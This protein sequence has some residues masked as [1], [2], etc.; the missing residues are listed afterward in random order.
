[1]DPVESNRRA[2]DIA[3]RKYVEESE[4]VLSASR[5]GTLFDLER[6]LLAPVVP[7]SI[8]VHLQSGNGTDDADLIRLGAVAVMGVDFS[9]VA[10]SS[11]QARADQLGLTIRYVT[12][13][14]VQVPLR[15]AST[16]V[17]YTGKGA[18]MWLP[19]LRTW[20]AETARLLRPGGHLFVFEAHPAAAL[21]TR[22][23][24]QARIRPDRTYFG[25]TRANDSFPASAIARFSVNPADEAV[26]WQ[27]TLSDVVTA[28]L[29]A[30]LVL[31]HLGEYPEPFWRPSGE[32]QAAA[33]AGGLP[34]SFALLATKPG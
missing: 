29:E 28:V 25:G 32:R 2:W 27:W 18:L 13:Q 21:W 30:G 23:V 1:M 15:T 7:G 16:D 10:T 12:A 9:S 6:A 17:V 26:E 33:W 4:A 31:R 5:D 34:N 24:D 19:D 20:A 3:N 14:A 22:D 8:V 11:A